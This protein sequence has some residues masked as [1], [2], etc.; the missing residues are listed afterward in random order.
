MRFLTPFVAI[1][2]TLLFVGCEPND[3]KEGVVMAGGQYVSAQTLNKGKQI[4]AEYCMACHGVDGDGNGVAAKGLQPPP[5]NFKLGIIKFGNVVSGE[6]PH[7]E[8]IY[9]ALKHGLNGSAM[10]P[11]DLKKDQ[12]VAVWQ[13]IKTFAPDTW[14]GKDKKLGE[15]LTAN[16]FKDPFTLARRDQAIELGKKVYHVEANCQSCHRGY[17]TLGEYDAMTK[18]LTGDGIEE[19]DEDF[20]K[21]KIQESDHGY[22]VIPPDF[23]WH[24][25]RSVRTGGKEEIE[26]LYLRLLAGVGGTAMPAWKDTLED[27]KIWALAYYVNHLRTFK[28]S[29]KRKEFVTRLAEGK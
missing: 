25:L 17:V 4:Y 21:L 6:L 15:S 9:K 10:L 27:H 8:A 3:F 22:A 23:T 1:L 11:W 14:I 19:L 16:E 26:D 24:E 7:D 18:E 13:Y 12:M 5:R 29:P 20:Y 28:N 2:S